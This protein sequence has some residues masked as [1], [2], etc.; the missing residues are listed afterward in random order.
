MR[1]SDW[2]S[3]VCSSDLQNACGARGRGIG[4]DRDQPFV[5]VAKFVRVLLGLRRREQLRA[6]GVGGE[7]GVERR[8]GAA[9]RFLRDIA[10]ARLARH[11]DAALVGRSEEHTSEL[12]SLMRTSYAVFCLKKKM[13]ILQVLKNIATIAKKSVGHFQ[14][15]PQN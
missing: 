2:S 13:R 10:D 11:F 3:D 4:V 12:Q 9:R 7:H 15:I 1:I 6:F 5:E 8:R 14:Q